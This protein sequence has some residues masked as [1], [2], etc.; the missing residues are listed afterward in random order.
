MRYLTRDIHGTRTRLTG[1]RRLH[2]TDAEPF[3]GGRPR[4]THE[5]CY[6]C[7][8]VCVEPGAHGAPPFSCAP[9]CGL[10]RGLGAAASGKAQPRRRLGALVVRGREWGV[11]HGVDF[12]PLVGTRRRQARRRGGRHERAV[13]LEDLRLHRGVLGPARRRQQIC[14][15][16]CGRSLLAGAGGAGS[17]HTE[18]ATSCAC[19]SSQVGVG[20][21][22]QWLQRRWRPRAE[23]WRL[24]GSLPAVTEEARGLRR[25]GAARG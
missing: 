21:G 20:L 8:Y 4:G 3:C 19:A 24:H 15:V 22:A 14:C 12:L 10:R 13:F 17:G 23:G 7:V 11:G 9:R 5:V 2:T 1:T 18:W 6:R 16:P 25:R